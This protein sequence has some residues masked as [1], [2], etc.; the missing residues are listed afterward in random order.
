M[1][2]IEF[3]L[4]RI[5]EDER[6]ARKGGNHNDVGTFARDNYGCLLV[7]PS[8][9]LADCAA[10][11]A[12]IDMVTSWEHSYMDEDM[13][14]SCPL[15]VAPGETEVGSGYSGDDGAVCRCGLEDRQL[16]PLRPLAAIYSDHPDYSPDWAL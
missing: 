2:I 10:K 6:E 3:L 9:V 1:T 4:A 13:W 12:I 15:A 16:E 14:Y 5:A 11:R 7:Q 8:R